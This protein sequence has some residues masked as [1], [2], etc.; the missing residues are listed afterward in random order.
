MLSIA[1]CGGGGNTGE[2]AAAPNPRA[3]HATQMVG[4]WRHGIVNAKG[5][6]GFILMAQHKGYYKQEG[7]DVDVKQFQ[8]STQILQGIISG[9]IDSGELSPASAFQAVAKGANL[10]II[11]STLDG[12]RYRLY[13]K[14]NI[15]NVADLKGKAV[16]VSEP[17]SLP[18]VFARAVMAAK[19][20][21]PSTMKAVSAGSD[22]Q[23]F[24]ALL[25][26]RVD[27]EASSIGF[28]KEIKPGDHVHVLAKAS[29]VV[30]KFPR[31]VIVANADSLKQKPNAAARFLAAEMQGISYAIHH[32]KAEIKVGSEASGIS[33]SNPKLGFIYDVTTKT[34]AASPTCEIPMKKLTFLQDF[35]MKNGFQKKRI[36]L[37]S[38]TDNSYRSK[39]LSLV[40]GKIPEVPK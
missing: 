40:A 37:D 18:D 39:A 11:G 1:A 14:S 26:G 19:G 34:M 3:S 27:A 23:R 4:P 5:D 24:K 30:P 25:A 21:N 35:M 22:A 36:D 13:A 31:F 29:D 38:I 28:T 20:V 10:K 2:S 17:G 8:G 12:L 32:K 7:V 15:K 33:A 16:G 9:S 6:G